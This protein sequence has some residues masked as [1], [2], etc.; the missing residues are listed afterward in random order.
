MR[1]LPLILGLCC[2]LMLTVASAQERPPRERIDLP[3]DF[4]AGELAA[5]FATNTASGFIE[6]PD[7]GIAGGPAL[8]P[9]GNAQMI[10]ILS[11]T[12]FSGSQ[13]AYRIALF[14]RWEATTEDDGGFALALGVAGDP[15]DSGFTLDDGE[16]AMGAEGA[17]YGFRAGLTNGGENLVRL[18]YVNA[19]TESDFYAAG[20]YPGDTVSLIPGNWYQLEIVTT[21][22]QL[23]L[24]EITVNLYAAGDDGTRG[25]LVAS[26]T[27]EPWLANRPLHEDAGV[28]LMFGSA[29]AGRGIGVV[30]SL[31]TTADMAPIDIQTA[32]ENGVIE[33]EDLGDFPPGSEVVL[34]ALPDEGYVF[35]RWSGDLR[36]TENPVLITVDER[37][38]ITAVFAPA[39]PFAHTIT[40]DP[41]VEH[42]T[43]TGF[44]TGLNTFD[45][46][47]LEENVYTDEFV[48]FYVNRFGATVI[49]FD[50]W[51]G[52]FDSVEGVDY[53]SFSP[54][55]ISY[56]DFVTDGELVGR[57]D[58]AMGYIRFMQRAKALNPE[59]K[60]I[61]AVWSPPGWMKTNGS[62][63]GGG[64]L[65]PEKYAHF[66]HYLGAWLAW[67]KEEYGLEL[68]ALSPQNELAFEQSFGSCFYTPEQFRDMLKVLGPQLEADG[69]GDVLIYGP[70]DMTLDTSRFMSYVNAVMDDPEAA[71]HL[72]VF[73]SHGYVDG[74]LSGNDPDANSVLWRRLEPFNREFWMTETS[75]EARSWGDYVFKSNNG[76]WLRGA[77]T[78]LA[79]KIHNSLQFGNVSVFNYWQISERIGVHGANTFS[80]MWE[81]E[82]TKKLPAAMHYYRYIR[83]GAVRIGATPSGDASRVDVTAWHHAD[84]QTMT[85]VILNRNVNTAQ[86]TLDLGDGP[87]P[88]RLY[89][90]RTNEDDQFRRLGSVAVVDGAASLDVPAQSQ[91]TL[92][93][94]YGETPAAEWR[95]DLYLGTM[96]FETGGT[97]WSLHPVFGWVWLDFKPWVFSEVHGWWYLAGRYDEAAGLSL[98]D[99]SY[100]WLFTREGW[101]NAFVVLAT[102]ERIT[103]DPTTRWPNRV[104]IREEGTEWPEGGQP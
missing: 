49:R 22:F 43:I 60:L 26:G 36:G 53:E 98:F 48:D 54:E 90:F 65:R 85:L 24:R 68:Y 96:A 83:P 57:R 4:A 46:G 84:Q 37:L 104:F 16:L 18:S 102:G 34:R 93:G 86:L 87:L 66:A 14:F 19:T 55:E 61:G 9:Q 82:W 44:G 88:A 27:V 72:D 7:G 59:I 32:A 35:A 71:P 97:G 47:F 5:L 41:S 77:F 74:V 30:D 42:Q 8:A 67:L 39:Q 13:A 45:G 50:I 73:A 63:N 12:N 28:H 38:Q 58:R 56:E 6:V 92:V 20:D 70:E 80:L 17:I 25:D 15:A 94:G 81:F 89:M 76:D 69:F 101:E 2:A 99:Q 3:V 64:S 1:C 75:G 62:W 21:T 40:V 78:G 29:G 100:G 52:V 95:R 31:N 51:S 10:H 103:F 23:W 33:F 11:A 79:G 91:V